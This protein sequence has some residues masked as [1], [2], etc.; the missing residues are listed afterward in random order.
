[1]RKILFILLFLQCELCIVNCAY[2]QVTCDSTGNVVLYSNY[3]GGILNINVDV[4]IPNLK[5]GVVSYE[6]VTINLTGP[7]VNNI[8]EIQFA[9]Y[10]TTTHHHCNNSPAVTSIVGAPPGTDTLIFMP[11]S[12]LSNTNG[13]YIVICNYS[14]DT[15]TNQGGCNTPDQIAA[16]FQQE[17]GGLLRYHFTQYGCWNGTYNISDGGNCCV[18]A[19]SAAPVA[20]FSAENQLCPGTCTDFINLSTNATSFEWTFPGGSPATSTDMNPINIC[21]STPGS[22]DVTLIATGPGGSDTIILNNY[23]TVFPYPP[24]QGMQQI[25]DTLFAN[26]GAT[27]Y[28]WYLNGTIIPGATDYFYLATESGDYN[29]ICTDANGCEVE[30]VIFNVIASIGQPIFNETLQLFPNPVVDNLRISSPV[31]DDAG[32]INITIYN[33]PGKKI[34]STVDNKLSPGSY[35]DVDCQLI[36]PGLYL[37]EIKLNQKIFRSKFVKSTFN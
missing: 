4:N 33:M 2:S 17:F 18:S 29:I 31:F 22:Y 11:T 24:P 7:F 28:Q 15:A 13:Y 3:D 32:E 26:P 12:P 1:M 8:T 6:M 35:Q 19:I 16:Y 37:L 9:G 10:S 5:I 34:F 30:A 25:G 21:Y 23:V 36:A 14:C 27:T 20:L